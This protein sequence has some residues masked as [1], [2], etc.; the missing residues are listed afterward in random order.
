MIVYG[1]HD[2]DEYADGTW[3]TADGEVAE[4]RAYA[5]QADGQPAT[6]TRYD[7]RERLSLDLL[8]WCLNGERFA[9]EIRT[10]LDLE[11]DV[12]ENND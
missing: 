7:I 11:P 8:V 10:I 12:E 4:A 1:V 5:M 3:F 9:S 6:V 2:C